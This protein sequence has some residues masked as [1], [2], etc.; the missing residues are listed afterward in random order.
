[1]HLRAEPPTNFAQNPQHA[2][3]EYKEKNINRTE[4]NS[5]YVERLAPPETSDT[6][7]E[8]E[9]GRELT[10]Y[11]PDRPSFADGYIDDCLTVA[12]DQ[13]DEVQRSQEA[14]PL[15]VHTIFRPLD[16]D[17]PVK[18]NDNISD[19][20]LKGEGQPSEKK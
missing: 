12:L 13:D 19:E 1:M 7:T 2:L 10:I 8:I 3:E 15:I 11:M 16:P 9:D 18:R 14:L 4:I 20:K 17:E 6:T 5:P